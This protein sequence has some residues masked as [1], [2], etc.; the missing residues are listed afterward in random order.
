MRVLLS[1]FNSLFGNAI[2]YDDGFTATHNNR[3]FKLYGAS[4][5]ANSVDINELCDPCGGII[6]TITSGFV[7]GFN[8]GFSAVLSAPTVAEIHFNMK[9][10]SR[11]K[12]LSRATNNGVEYELAAIKCTIF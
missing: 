3:L 4:H 12:N 7:C 9:L 11:S 2:E 1:N 5:T 6:S 8:F 10:K